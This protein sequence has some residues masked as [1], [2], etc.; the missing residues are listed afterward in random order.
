MS[1]KAARQ[2]FRFILFAAFLFSGLTV[3]TVAEA[4]IQLP[5]SCRMGSCSRTTIESK[6][7][8]RS[9]SFGTLYLVDTSGIQ[10]PAPND[11]DAELAAQDY[12]RFVNF[13]GTD[14]VSGTSQTYVFCSKELPSVMF[15]AEGSYRVNR[16]A[17]F[18]SPFGYN[19]NSYQEYLATCHNLAGPDY[20]SLDVSSLL[21]REGYTDRYVSQSR[22]F[23]TGNPLDVMR[24]T[25]HDS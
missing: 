10:Y 7:A 9:N 15:E 1:T 14:L 4:V 12:E 20:F 22:Q 3:A 18:E 17:M 13:Y 25:E 5:E 2:F 23:T 11:T 24:L 8:L 6:E 16:L 21:L 19:R